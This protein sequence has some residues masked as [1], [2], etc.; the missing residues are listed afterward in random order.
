MKIHQQHKAGRRSISQRN[1]RHRN[2]QPTLE[3]LD[4]RLAL[5][6]MTTGLISLTNPAIGQPL[7][8]AAVI[9][10]QNPYDN[11]SLVSDP[12]VSPAFSIHF[13]QPID[14]TALTLSD[15]NLFQIN[16]DGSTR[17]VE[18]P[19]LRYLE[20]GNYSDPTSSSLILSITSP[21]DPG[22]Y[23]LFLA[24][25]SPLNNNLQLGTPPSDQLIDQFSVGAQTANSNSVHSLGSFTQSVTTAVLPVV[26]ND[27]QGSLNEL[28]LPDGTSWTISPS[29]G[30]ADPDQFRIV[31]FDAQ[32]QLILSTSGSDLLG[33]NQGIHSGRY[34]LQIYMTTSI[35]GMSNPTIPLVVTGKSTQPVGVAT[36]KVTPFNLNGSDLN[37]DT[38]LIDL[39][40][41]EVTSAFFDASQSAFT[42]TD[43]NGQSWPVKPSAYDA[44]T[45]QIT[46]ALASYLPTGHY[47]LNVATAGETDP[48]AHLLNLGSFDAVFHALTAG[49]L[50]T[51]FPDVVDSNDRNPTEILPGQSVIQQFAV[52]ETQRYQVLLSNPDLSGQLVQL[53]RDATGKTSKV[54]IDLE[55]GKSYN[56]TP[57]I[58][59]IVAV[60]N[61]QITQR[62][63]FAVIVNKVLPAS[64]SLGGVAQL[65]ATLTQ[66][67]LVANSPS[68]Q[69]NEGFA[70]PDLQV[71][72]EFES[73][74]LKAAASSDL[75]ASQNTGGRS[76][77]SASFSSSVLLQ[78]PLGSLSNTT[79]SANATALSNHASLIS[80]SLASAVHNT[81]FLNPNTPNVVIDRGAK[82]QS[83]PSGFR[84]DLHNPNPSQ[85]PFRW[86][87]DRQMAAGPLVADNLPQST[88]INVD[89]IE[90]TEIDTTKFSTET[91][92][93]P[94]L[95]TSDWLPT[96]QVESLPGPEAEPFDSTSELA[97]MA[98][99]ISMVI[100]SCVIVRQ[101]KTTRIGAKLFH[102]QLFTRSRR[103]ALNWL[104]S[105]H[106]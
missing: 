55:L 78:I 99:P 47:T 29:F 97:N 92:S 95:A 88:Q 14:T 23:S 46:L 57:G 85:I 90:P 86:P 52:I 105:K 8:I 17:Q 12:T 62:V 64:L 13:N 59:Q 53:T 89:H 38:L 101:I 5:S 41:I 82:F 45:K 67:T 65:P 11:T 74:I 75:R 15:F 25:T 10:I 51:I 66:S 76:D 33:L 69:V 72:G 21:L 94:S 3:R 18:Q 50:G 44:T 30:S 43:Q 31:L 16:A 98:S 34:Y 106:T 4:Q 96:S 58:Y 22:R 68:I 35:S 84:H 103:L 24:A 77:T 39:T 28:D 7:S 61:T 40:G 60:N 26:N 19:G 71:A 49:N 73:P 2:F 63:S 32:K 87:S 9:P 100:A 27:M 48:A 104:G 83:A 80:D 102:R 56:L 1:R 91:P 81:I 93:D 6:G 70:H 36:Q 54:I 79:A 42:L 20:D 37:P